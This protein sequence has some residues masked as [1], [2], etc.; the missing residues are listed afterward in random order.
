MT[1]SVD[2]Y[3]DQPDRIKNAFQYQS[4][5][6]SRNQSIGKLQVI[7]IQVYCD[8]PPELFDSNPTTMSTKCRTAKKKTTFSWLS[9]QCSI[10]YDVYKHIDYKYL[11]FRNDTVSSNLILIN[12]DCNCVPI[13]APILQMSL[14]SCCLNIDQCLFW[15][16]VLTRFDT[17][18]RIRIVFDG[19]SY[20]AAC[21]AN[22]YPLKIRTSPTINTTVSIYA[23]N[24]L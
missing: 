13:E 7:C 20:S 18:I 21:D 8:M 3:L 9:R 11:M 14:S 23:D 15:I 10:G 5:P 16:Q 17:I 19:Q 22:S 2:T 1:F 4:T 6:R 24:V 12:A